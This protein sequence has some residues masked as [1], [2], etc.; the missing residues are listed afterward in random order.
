MS[1]MEMNNK[2]DPINP[3]AASGRIVVMAKKSHRRRNILLIAAG[4][5]L[6]LLAGAAAWYFLMGPAKTARQTAFTI[7][8]QN[9]SKD[10]I[11]SLIQY[12]VA[13]GASKDT[14]AKQAFDMYKRQKAAEKTGIV[15]TDDQIATS[16]KNLFPNLMPS[17]NGSTDPNTE[18]W[19]K[20]V[21]YDNALTNFV[22]TTPTYSNANGYVFLFWF[23]QRIDYNPNRPIDGFG[24]PTL[25][26]ADRQYASDRANYYRQ[27]L[28]DKTMTPDQV[29]QSVKADSRLA[30]TYGL[31]DNQSQAFSGLAYSTQGNSSLL[32]VPKDAQQRIA[33]IGKQ[34]GLDTIQVGTMEEGDPRNDSGFV[35]GD[36]RTLKTTETFF[37]LIDITKPATASFSATD[38]TNNLNQLS[39]HYWGVK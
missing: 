17:L 20:L 27:Q 16:R 37:Y 38:F 25:I 24:D 18:A 31:K 15:I 30:Y 28:A 29:V 11:N 13:N 39:T 14:T 10:Q 9:Y 2:A 4:V 26:A 7:D 19:V 35:E 6:L 32:Y 21:S 12:P 3:T 22:A 23:S 1:D 5:V 33:K 34:A 8:G 36:A